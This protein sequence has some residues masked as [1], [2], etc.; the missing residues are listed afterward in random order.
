MRTETLHI[1]VN[2]DEKRAL[3]AAAA[4]ARMPLARYL[5]RLVTMNLA[6][7]SELAAIRQAVESRPEIDAPRGEAMEPDDLRKAVKSAVADGLADIRRK[8]ESAALARARDIELDTQA[9]VAAI[10]N[11]GESVSSMLLAEITAQRLA[12][13]DGLSPDEKRRAF[14][15]VL[16]M[17]FTLRAIA[18]PE[19]VETAHAEL[20]RLG[21]KPVHPE[22]G[23]P[24]PAIEPEPVP[25]PE[26]KRKFGIF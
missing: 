20:A 14:A 2:P 18:R 16:E 15:A 23:F 12:D 22:M 9:A 13:D 5:R 6:L 8:E 26:K 10:Q 24:P 17:L 7:D 21:I 4:A 11:A 19:R 3:D 1:R 25:E